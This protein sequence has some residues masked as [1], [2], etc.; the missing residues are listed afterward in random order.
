M[1]FQETLQHLSPTVRE[2]LQPFLDVLQLRLSPTDWKRMLSFIGSM[3][4]ERRAALMA[5]IA[6]R[7]T[8]APA[9]GTEAPD[10]ELPRLGSDERVRLS[11]FRNHKPVALI[12]G[13][14]S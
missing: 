3:D 11:G 9:V 2:Q 12:F 4:A 13:S 6:Q 7:E 10:F 1:T 8:H 14:F 5:F